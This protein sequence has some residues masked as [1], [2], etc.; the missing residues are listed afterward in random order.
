MTYS[1]MKNIL[2][3]ITDPVEKLEMVMD[4]GR[5]LDAVPDGADCTEIMGCASQ[6]EFCRKGN[7]FFA[8][9]D[10]AMVRGIVAILL[11]MVRGKTLLEIKQM[12]IGAEF[13]TLNINLGAGRLNGL[14]SMISFFHNL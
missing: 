10:S 11:E 1:E 2:L 5:N 13:K 7:Q 12:D 3:A 9:A 6:V 4:L 14:N 8:H